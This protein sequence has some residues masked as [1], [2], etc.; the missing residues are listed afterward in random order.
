MCAEPLSSSFSKYCSTQVVEKKGTA[1]NKRN[2]LDHSQIIFFLV[3]EV[4]FEAI[5]HIACEKG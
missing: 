4:Y 3:S 2:P 5:Y 1:S